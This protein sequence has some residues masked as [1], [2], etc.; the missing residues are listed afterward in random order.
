MN[1]LCP[2]SSNQLNHWS[3]WNFIQARHLI[4]G[5]LSYWRLKCVWHWGPFPGMGK[6]L[7]ACTLQSTGLY[8]L[9]MGELFSMTILEGG[10]CISKSSPRMTGCW[11]CWVRPMHFPGIGDEH[12]HVYFL[13]CQPVNWNW[14]TNPSSATC[15]ENT[16][17]THKWRRK[18]LRYACHPYTGN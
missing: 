12:W 1:K 4:L 2:Y 15:V 7:M 3:A 14:D 5:N 16:H 13:Y 10:R 17:N 9:L 18:N 6:G 8:N 11:Q